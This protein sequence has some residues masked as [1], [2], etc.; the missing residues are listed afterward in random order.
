MIVRRSLA[1]LLA[2]P[3]AGSA[4]AQD[5]GPVR[6]GREGQLDQARID[7]A[8]PA[9]GA[10]L[11][12]RDGVIWSGVSGMRRAGESDPVV[13]D[14][15]WHLGSN[16]KAMTAA[17]YARLVEAGLAEWS[18]TLAELFPH[19]TVDPALASATVEAVLSHR[20]GL[21]EGAVMG[22]PWLMTA[23]GDERSLPVQ[24]ADLARAALSAPPAGTPGQFAYSNL[25]YVVVGSAIERITGQAWEEAM[26]DR[27]FAPLAL[28]SGGFGAPPSPAPWGH[29]SMAGMLTGMDPAS[30]G[31]DNP[32]AL[33]PAGTAHMALADYARWLQVFLGAGPDGFVSADSLRRL[34]TPAKGTD[35]A[36]GWGA[37]AS[38]PWARG[39][40]LAHE[41]SNTMWRV[42]ALVAPEQ[43]LAC[44]VAANRDTDACAQLAVALMREASAGT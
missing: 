44:A 14:D 19:V 18:A 1:A 16:T 26:R 32:L 8:S 31:S 39:P 30:P 42:A 6:E 10:V 24:R 35:Y 15:R 5:S 17:L 34:T 43:G 20:A 3:F 22:R 2:L 21:M 7:A 13:L 23:R 33:G 37:Y 9:M 41:G 25:N 11:L 27:I 28:T 40:V 4:C 29:R 36:L 12:N 38:R